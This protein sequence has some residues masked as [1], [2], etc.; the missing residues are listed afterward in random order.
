MTR[1]GEGV[2][3]AVRDVLFEEGLDVS[4]PRVLAAIATNF[5]LGPAGP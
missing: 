4:D 2:S 1:I 5:D 3:A